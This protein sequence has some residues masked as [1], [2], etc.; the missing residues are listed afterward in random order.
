MCAA[1]S[2]RLGFISKL[3]ELFEIRRAV[4]AERA[5]EIRRQRVAL[6]DITA[7]LADIPSLFLRDDRLR[8]DVV[9]VELIGIQA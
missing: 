3:L 2:G 5:D 7:D 6:I 8:L 9:E 1:V 4:L